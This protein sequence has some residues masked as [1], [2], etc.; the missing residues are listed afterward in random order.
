MKIDGDIAETGGLTGGQVEGL[1]DLVQRV[2]EK[3]QQ[4]G[5]G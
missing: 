5:A 4:K 2:F 1:G 3:G